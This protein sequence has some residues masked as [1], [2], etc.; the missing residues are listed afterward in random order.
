MAKAAIAQEHKN[1]YESNC[2]ME[3]ARER[4]C[5]GKREREKEKEKERRRQK[6]VFAF[7]IPT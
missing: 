1:M 6:T 5:V 3:R 7:K 2:L 4:V